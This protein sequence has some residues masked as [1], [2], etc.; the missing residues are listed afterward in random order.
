[1]SSYQHEPLFDIHPVM[2]ASIE[3]FYAD[4][5]LISFGWSGAGWFWQLRLRGFA[6]AGRA[7]GPF[8]TRYSAFRD[9][10]ITSASS[11]LPIRS[12]LTTD[13]QG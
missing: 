11:S 2:G 10:M 3:V 1:M 5:S 7:R 6:P 8:P 9:A 12:A 13:L 4:T